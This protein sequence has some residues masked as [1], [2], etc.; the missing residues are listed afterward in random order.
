MVDV[1]DVYA[2]A[3]KI[4]QTNPDA[5]SDKHG[6]TELSKADL[7]QATTLAQT[8]RQEVKHETQQRVEP[9]CKELTAILSTCKE[10]LD[11]MPNSEA[12]EKAFMAWM[13]NMIQKL[14]NSKRM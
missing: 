14:P 9:L 3:G 7:D 12:D 4:K 8:V 5:F 1:A 13:K 2:V 10:V 11:S 6:E